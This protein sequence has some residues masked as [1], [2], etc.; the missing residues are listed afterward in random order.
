MREGL[1]WWFFG[2][3]AFVVT[4]AARFDLLDERSE[5]RGVRL[6]AIEIA[7]IALLP[8]ILDSGRL[9][10]TA[11]PY[12]DTIAIGIVLAG[13]AALAFVVLPV[14]S[15]SREAIVHRGPNAVTASRPLHV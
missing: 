9:V 12:T 10:A 7:A 3:I 15:R 5:S 6:R 2:L 1:H 11:W 4:A 8:A 13:S 14:G